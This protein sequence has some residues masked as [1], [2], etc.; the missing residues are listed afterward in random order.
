MIAKTKKLGRPLKYAGGKGHCAD[1]L[2]LCRPEHFDEYREP[3]C[4]G[5]LI[6]DYRALPLSLSRSINDRDEPLI[7]FFTQLRDDGSFISRFLKIKSRIIGHADRTLAAFESAK[8]DY[9]T[10]GVSYLIL[11]RFALN[12]V[13]RESR[14]NIASV[15]FEY[16]ADP[17]MLRPFTQSKMEAWR[18]ILRDVKITCDDFSIILEKPVK[19]GH[20]CWS[21]IDPPYW[22]NLFKHRGAELYEHVLDSAGHE[23]LR[24]CLASLNPKT[25]KF[26]MTLCDTEMS[27]SLYGVDPR[28]EVYDRRSLYG[29]M[30]TGVNKKL[31]NEIVVTNYK[32]A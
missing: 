19:R 20:V 23:R 16:L 29:L 12:Q 26:L 14:K 3:F 17:A 4:G 21:F 7:N 24:D 8:E 32:I 28:F 5:S 11:R 31:I 13:V 9:R 15:S 10:N 2:M 6:W 22:S 27:H 25:H 18:R 30:G 1:Q